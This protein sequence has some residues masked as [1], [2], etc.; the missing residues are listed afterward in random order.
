M[1]E[2]KYNIKMKTPIGDQKGSITFELK[3]SK[4]IG[5]LEIMGRSNS[6]EGIAEGD[7]F[8]FGGETSSPIGNV[9]IYIGW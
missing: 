1:L 3:D 5:T 2:G 6:F 9:R 8:N 4:L 7:N